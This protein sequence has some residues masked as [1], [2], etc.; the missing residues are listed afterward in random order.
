MQ[1]LN[2]V[3]VGLCGAQRCSICAAAFALLVGTMAVVL[4]RWPYEDES[5]EDESDLSDEEDE[6]DDGNVPGTNAE[7][8]W[9][10]EAA[11]S[12][13]VAAKEYDRWSRLGRLVP[14]SAVRVQYVQQAAGVAAGSA[15]SPVPA[16]VLAVAP[17]DASCLDLVELPKSAG[18]LWPTGCPVEPPPPPSDLA[19][20]V[21][22]DLEPAAAATRLEPQPEAA[23]ES[24]ILVVGGHRFEVLTATLTAVPGSFFE[25]L[26]ARL[27]M[28]GVAERIA[29]EGVVIDRPGE[30]FGHVL[31]FLSSF[32][33]AR[34]DPSLDAEACAAVLTEADF[35]MLEPLK[36]LMADRLG[37]NAA[38]APAD[39]AN[40]ELENSLRNLLR[41][42]RDAPA[43]ADLHVGLVSVYDPAPSPSAAEQLSRL[44]ATAA[45]EEAATGTATATAG[46]YPLL[47]EGL[48][49]TFGSSVPDGQPL[50]CKTIEDYKRRFSKRFPRLIEQLAG[51]PQRPECGWMIAGGAALSAL[52]C[53]EQAASLFGQSDVDIFIY[54]RTSS[55]AGGEAAAA[56][57][58]TQMAKEIYDAVT[59]E[60]TPADWQP[61]TTWAS[62]PHTGWNVNRTLFTLNIERPDSDR[63]TINVP[64]FPIQIILRVYDSPAEVLLGFDVD[65][66]C[67]GFDGEQVWALPR[68]LAALKNGYSILNPL[69]R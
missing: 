42:Q 69:H 30:L 66:S 54:A 25:G 49:P 40:R 45:R 51:C 15:E 27:D 28:G 64:K 50:I 67:V 60:D 9:L 10:R 46:A 61:P 47:L 48:N 62:R 35:Y 56:A 63:P 17:G 19:E 12:G 31:E 34:V 53:D 5:D 59:P 29:D 24:A 39:L 11:A 4:G 38:L 41:T 2:C 58:A 20:Q 32:P 6:E 3:D 18:R 16:R 23:D 37:P 13:S 22:R 14:G 55:A 43:L 26:L 33:L 1:C 7:A 44:F 65:C 8:Q 68:A 21:F 57:A 52:H 36:Q